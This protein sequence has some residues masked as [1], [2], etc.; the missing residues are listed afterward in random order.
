MVRAPGGCRTNINKQEVGTIYQ[1]MCDSWLFITRPFG[2][3]GKQP[4]PIR[5][6]TTILLWVLPAH[7]TSHYLSNAK[8]MAK[9]TDLY[10]E[11]WPGRSLPPDP[12]KCYNY[13]NLHRNSRQYIISLSVVTLWYYR[14]TSILYDCQKIGN[15]PRKLST[16]VQILGHRES[17]LATQILTPK[18]GLKT[19]CKPS[20]EGGPP[21]GGHHSHISIN[22]W[23][24]RQNHHHNDWWQTLDRT[25]KKCGST[26][27]PY[28][29]P[30]AAG[31]RTP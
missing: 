26:G 30:T 31:I 10:W 1:K 25:R 24:H 12:W 3:I 2:T 8:Q 11:N 18:G 29:I 20:R 7:Y 28:T 19:I 23:V 4:F 13:V 9:K 5:I 27:H 14:C 21:S 22:V 17:Q 15:I 6:T 16:Q